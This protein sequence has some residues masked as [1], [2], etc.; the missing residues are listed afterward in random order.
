M[1]DSSAGGI[2]RCIKNDAENNKLYQKAEFKHF[3][4]K[5]IVHNKYNWGFDEYR[6]YAL[7]RVQEKVDG[8][9]IYRKRD[10]IV[11]VSP[12]DG[13]L[14]IDALE[15]GQKS[16]MRPIEYVEV[17]DGTVL[18]KLQGGRTLKEKA[19]VHFQKREFDLLD[20]NVGHYYCLHNTICSD[21]NYKGREVVKE[22]NRA[23]KIKTTQLCKIAE[24]M[25]YRLMG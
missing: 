23:L 8:Y 19:Y 21:M 6:K 1:T 15:H 20:V 2:L 18:L 12:W 22:D 5:L 16:T 9:Q 13:F 25:K 3:D 14:F 10:A 11:D 17:C 7:L 4:W 24:I